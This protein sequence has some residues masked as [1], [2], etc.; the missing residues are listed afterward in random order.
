MSKPT[1]NGRRRSRRSRPKSAERQ[2]GARR[3]HA[4]PRLRTGIHI[5]ILG[6]DGVTTLDLVGPADVFATANDVWQAQ[7]G[8][9]P[10]YRITLLGLTRQRFV[11]ESGLRFEAHSLLDVASAP[12][13]FVIPGGGGLRE[14]EANARLVAWLRAHAH[15]CR[16]IAS[17]CT[18]IYGLAPSGLLDG[19]RV[20][21]H[22]RF[23]RDVARRFPKLRVEDDALYLRDGRFYTSAGITAGIDLSL[24]LVEEDLGPGVALAV[25]RELVVY[26][27]RPGG[28]AQ[29]SEPLRMQVV[30]G[31][32]FAD[33]VA[34]ML[35]HL[36]QDLSVEALAAR[37]GLSPRHF[38]RRFS[39]VFGRAPARYVEDLRMSEARRMLDEDGVSIQRAAAAVGFAGTDV[40][41]RAFE[42]RFGLSPGDY[43]ERFG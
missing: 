1:G 14:D 11:A 10:R 20:T 28:Q 26:L 9:P 38:S 43:R 3:D 19:R 7:H 6:Y 25:A 41:R 27:K 4:L 2:A 18:G 5:G 13:T 32:R 24:A 33:L 36:D 34:W 8:G 42:R 15:R 12:H 17:V 23:A 37:A 35:G 30:S 39:A 16:R 31:D 21:T 22:W 29:Y 40:F